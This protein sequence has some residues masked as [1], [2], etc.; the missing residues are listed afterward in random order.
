MA[1]AD[2]GNDAA[3][4]VADRIEPR[5]VLWRGPRFITEVFDG[6]DEALAALEAVQGALVSTGFQTLDWLT[7]LYEDLAP[8]RHA[9]PRVV[10][11]SE[12]NSGKVVLILP[13]LIEKERKLTV[14]RFADLGVSNYCGPI[15]G[16]T[17]VEKRRSIR[18]VWRSVLHAMPDVDLIRL[19]RMPA[20]IGRHPNP[21]MTRLGVTPALHS[22]NVLVIP[23][24]VEA[25]L[26]A[27]GKKYH[28]E[29]ERC[30]RLW[31][32]E[33]AP[34]FYRA[35]MPEE[36]ARVCSILEEQQAARYGRFGKGHILDEPGYRAFYERLAV[37]GS[38][39]GLASLFAL[40]AGNEI[41]ATLLGIVHDGTFTLLHAATARE[42]WG[43]L[44][45]GRLII[46]EAMKHFVAQGVR[47][48]DFGLGDDP[49]KRGFGVE[50]VPLYDLIVAR[51]LSVVPRAVYYRLKGRLRKS[52]HA[53]SVFHL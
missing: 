11:V 33:D 24:T 15:L 42:A 39:A 12:R 40:E 5:R 51:D 47:R 32:K 43:Y 29:V 23:E 50:E 21:L 36:I 25:F 52:A 7:V 22:G 3:R 46:I 1:T 27:R 8:S 26:R 31:Q 19:E 9:V 34:R 44:S 10:V 53:R 20:E 35:A 38:D 49:F 13:L 48:F 4:G 41:I 28:K 37:D 30:H 17:L 6:A 18:R 16:P 2:F 45:P 14:A